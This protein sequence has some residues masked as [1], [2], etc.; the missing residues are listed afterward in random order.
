[1]SSNAVRSG[2]IALD[3]APVRRPP[4]MTQRQAAQLAK[5]LWGRRGAAVRATRKGS[6]H[7]LGGGEVC[8]VGRRG[9]LVRQFA[10]IFGEGPTWEEAFAAALEKSDR[11]ARWMATGSP[12]LSRRSA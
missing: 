10:V 3:L 11:V 6:V 5:K 9:P 8:S 4:P 1:M 2:V 7:A 12:V